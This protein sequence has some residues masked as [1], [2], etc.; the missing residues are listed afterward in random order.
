MTPSRDSDDAGVGILIRQMQDLVAEQ[1]L[2]FVATICPDGTPKLSPKD[3]TLVWDA[4][5]LVFADTHSPGPVADLRN[6]PA[7]EVNGV[8]PLSRR[9]YRF[10][11]EATVPGSG[12]E[13]DQGIDFF[14]AQG[15]RSP[16][17]HVVFIRVQQASELRS[18]LY[19][20]GLTE[21][22]IRRQWIARWRDRLDEGTA[23]S[24]TR[25][26]LFH[27]QARHAARAAEESLERAGL[28]E[29]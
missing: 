10:K 15:V 27:T 16:I 4:N 6:N 11:G 21:A 29:G 17:R 14:H 20:L 5:H 19:D 1:R 7:A 25:Q 28:H 22:E 18:P 9:D 2:G 8:D 13:F 24:D 23:P 26:E 3:T 12:P